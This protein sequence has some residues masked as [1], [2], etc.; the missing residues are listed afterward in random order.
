MIKALELPTNQIPV[1]RGKMNQPNVITERKIGTTVFRV[2]AYR[3][4]TK[5]EFNL[6]LQMWFQKQ[7]KKTLPENTTITI[8]TIFGVF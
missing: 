2:L 7:R 5:A 6:A 3:K 8:Q 4:V 1:R